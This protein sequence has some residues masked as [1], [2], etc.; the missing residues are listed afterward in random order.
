MK[1]ETK[2]RNVNK[3]VLSAYSSGYTGAAG[4]A[5]TLSKI[6]SYT[7]PLGMRLLLDEDT[8]LQIK[9]HG[10]TE[11]KDGCQVEVRVVPA[12]GMGYKTLAQTSYGVIKTNVYGDMRFRPAS[13]L[14]MITPNATIEVWLKSD[15]TVYGATTNSVDFDLEAK[16]VT[17]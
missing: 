15:Q 11:T 16:Y 10:A 4:T 2:L 3:V 9:D 12:T 5:S 7:V 8:I 14:W 6:G 17:A 1:W 13:T